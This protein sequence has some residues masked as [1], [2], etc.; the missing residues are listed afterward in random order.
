MSKNINYQLLRNYFYYNVHELAAILGI[1]R[2][3][4]RNWVPRGLTVIR[5]EKNGWYFFGNDV[6][7]FHKE[8]KRKSK[9][10]SPIGGVRCGSCKRIT[11][12]NTSTIRLIETGKYFGNGRNKQIFIKGNCRICGSRCVSFSSSNKVGEFLSQYPK[13]LNIDGST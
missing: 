3:T 9:V 11:K 1:S 6:K 13:Y 8:E 5:S 4:V 2:T 7:K 10:K 12:F